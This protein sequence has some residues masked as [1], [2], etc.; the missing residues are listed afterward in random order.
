MI[1][2]AV[3]LV[4]FSLWNLIRPNNQIEIYSIFSSIAVLVSS[5]FIS[6]QRF[7][8]R[9]MM[10]RNCYIRLDELYAKAI[11]IDKFG[12]K[13]SIDKIESEYAN[14]L[15]NIENH[16]DY[17]YLCMRYSLRNNKDTTLPQFKF[18]NYL[19]YFYS[20]LNRIIFTVVALALPFIFSFIMLKVVKY[21]SVY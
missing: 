12:N 16:S 21:V 3:A 10:M 15:I 20:K 4:F 17:D 19:V 7:S 8:E 5:I 11:N 9:A 1:F 2:Y 13:D 6:S 14:T 18:V